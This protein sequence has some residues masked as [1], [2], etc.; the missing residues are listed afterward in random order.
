MGS[1]MV[2]TTRSCGTQ[3]AGISSTIRAGAAGSRMYRG[4]ASRK[5]RCG[6]SFSLYSDW[7]IH[8]CFTRALH[9]ES[10]KSNM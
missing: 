6:Q 4:V 10:F 3:D 9:V 7:Y 2:S 8:G 5:V 1:R